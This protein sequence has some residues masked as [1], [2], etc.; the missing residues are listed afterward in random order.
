MTIA[1]PNEQEAFEKEG[2]IMYDKT[3]FDGDFVI[4][5]QYCLPLETMDFK[6]AKL[7]QQEIKDGMNLTI[8]IMHKIEEL[9]KW[10]ID[11]KEHNADI[12]T[13]YVYKMG[14]VDDLKIILDKARIKI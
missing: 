1:Y 9:M 11:N 5:L 8:I 2:L 7:M 3:K 10:L 12:H 14:Q 4:P 13:E 6:K